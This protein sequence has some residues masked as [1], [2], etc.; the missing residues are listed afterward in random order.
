MK[1][2]FQ[3]GINNAQHFWTRCSRFRPHSDL[4]FSHK[5]Y[6]D[7]MFFCLWRKTVGVRIRNEFLPGAEFFWLWIKSIYTLEHFFHHALLSREACIPFSISPYSFTHV[8]AMNLM[9]IWKE[10]GL[11]YTNVSACIFEIERFL[12]QFFSAL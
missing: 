1:T 3:G 9:H 5:V 8:W 11:L 12:V 2:S 6:K 4:K 10:T 7:R